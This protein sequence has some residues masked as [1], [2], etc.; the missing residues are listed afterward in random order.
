MTEIIAWYRKYRPSGFAELVGQGHIK[1]AILGAIKTGNISHAYLFCGPRG[2]GKTT[3][4]RLLAKA[5]ICLQPA[6]DGLPCSKCERCQ[7][8]GS[9][10]LVDVLEIDAASNRGIDEIRDLREKVAFLPTIAKKKVY[11]IDEVH[12][13][14]KEA[15]NALLKMLE[16]PPA[17]A[18]FILATTEAHKIPATI[19][20]RCQRFD[21]RRLPDKE[22]SARLSLITD[23]EGVK[24]APEALALIA[25]LAEGSLR[26]AISLLEQLSYAG[27]LSLADV[28][29]GAGLVDQNLIERWHVLTQAGDLIK[30]INF[31]E[32]LYQDGVNL[33]QFTFSLI[34]SLRE[35]LLAQV[36]I[37][38]KAAAVANLRQINLLEEASRAM[39]T[40]FLPQL[41]LEQAVIKLLAGKELSAV[42]APVQ[43][44][45]VSQS[46][47]VAKPELKLPQ[48]KTSS[49]LS[50]AEVKTKWDEIIDQLRLTTTK[51]SLAA[52]KPQAIL[53]SGNLMIALDAEFN[54]KKL[55]DI[56]Q[57]HDLEEAL[58]HVFGQA[59]KVEFCVV[60]AEAVVVEA[61]EEKLAAEIATIFGGELL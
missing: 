28:K 57:R 11:I 53:A 37:G 19:I 38:A 47:V 33:M 13:L 54:R 15:F 61:S 42:A 3:L 59:L 21:F 32:E 31:I 22:I 1:K 4:A 58:Q 48:T 24:A 10:R 5:L 50:L 6:K 60:A 44:K 52:A 30:A 25:Q 8:L 51:F 16:E 49:R 14:T 27:K 18:H 7:E 12:M 40:A 34:I 45:V 9:S 20:S 26:D 29:E 39:K 2:T 23:N 46:A 55:E 56:K 43:Q 35:K 36:A 17:H 41:P